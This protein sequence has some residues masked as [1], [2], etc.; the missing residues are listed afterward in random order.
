[1]PRKARLVVEG[2]WIER[3]RVFSDVPPGEAFWYENSLGLAEVAVGA[4][5]A[6]ATLGLRIG[7]AVGVEPS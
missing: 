3:A 5:S 1:V 4:G 2:R 7:Q 6:T